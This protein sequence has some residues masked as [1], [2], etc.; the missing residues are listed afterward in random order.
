MIRISIRDDGIGIPKD[1]DI[2]RATS[3]GLK[4]IRSLVQQLQGTLVIEST[5]RGS[6]VN[7]E[8]P[9]QMGR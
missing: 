8:F 3:L 1:V 9:V 4:L 6:V 7:V 2:S 5:D